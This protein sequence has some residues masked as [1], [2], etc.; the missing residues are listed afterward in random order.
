MAEEIAIPSNE[1]ELISG[2]AG[3]ETIQRTMDQFL[4]AAKVEA[5]Y[6]QPIQQGDKIIIPSAEVIS[7]MGFGLG[8]GANISQE[9]DGIKIDNKGSGGGGGGR[10]FSRPVAIIIAGPEEI[11]IEPVMDITKILLAALTTFGF[12]AGMIARMSRPIKPKF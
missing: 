11:R 7:V 10:V 6:G 5:V 2:E 4:S 12:I 9:Q 8:T 1:K 3:L